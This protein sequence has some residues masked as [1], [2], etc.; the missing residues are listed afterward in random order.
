MPGIVVSI[1]GRRGIVDGDRP[2]QKVRIVRGQGGWSKAP[3]L[4]S[5]TGKMISANAGDAR[6]STE[7][8]TARTAPENRVIEC[9]VDGIGSGLF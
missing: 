5:F 2:G 3:V 9:S 7:K 4:L 8:T 6:K 1:V